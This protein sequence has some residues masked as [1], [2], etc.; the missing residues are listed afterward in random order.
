VSYSLSIRWR[1]RLAVALV[2][3][4]APYTL[5][6]TV[7]QAAPSAQARLATVAKEAP[8]R[9]V[10]AIAQF[11]PSFSER[12]AKA[13]VRRHGGKVTARVPLINGLAVRLPA[14]QAAILARNGNV[15]ALTLNSRVHGT[16]IEDGALATRFP[17]TIKAD[18]V[19]RRGFTGKGIGVAV[20]DTGIAGDT[21]DF[22]DATG[23]S[24][25]IANAVTSRTATTAGDGFGHGT[26]VAGI[27]AG[28]SLNRD[29]R[30]PFYGKYIGVAPDANLIAVKASDEAG[31]STVLDVI[32]GLQFVVDHKA[33]FNIRV[34]NLSVSTDTPQSYKNDPLDAA[35]EYAWQKG[36]VVVA[37]SGNR[38]A[39]ADA[40]RYAPANDPFVISVGGSDENGDYGRGE[41]ASW[42]STGRT[43]DGFAKPEVMAPGA[44]IV[45]VLSQSS[46]FLALC[47]NCSIGGS[48]FKAGG[49]SMAAPVVAGAVALLLQARPNLTPDQVKTILTQTDKPIKGQAG[50][51]VIDIEQALYTP[52][53]TVSVNKGLVPNLLIAAINRA[54]ID[55]SRWTRSSWSSAT[56]AFAAG[57]ARSS[58]S[59][60]G[61]DASASAIDPT[62]SSWS[63]SSWSSAG[64]DASEESAAYEQAIDDQQAA[65]ETTLA[66]PIPV[67]AVL[68][69]DE[70]TAEEPAPQGPVA[71]PVTPAP[72]VTP[73]APVTEA[74]R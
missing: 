32:N 13:L 1:S 19:W 43:Q 9:K 6:E 44:H 74:V 52:T 8:A 55:I 60:H 57:W 58:W 45:S 3:V 4:A 16:A 51:G 59:C 73:A 11:K 2:A 29:R 40:V 41:R 50:A 15:L 63:R 35:V 30:D 34:V 61:C 27:I 22:K 64:E 37:A 38:G 39:N 62:R 42:S 47:P 14:K 53:S 12:R 70:P 68:P 18:K 23:A 17:K 5:A 28:N 69:T 7:A 20:I 49:T 71:K 26:H 72:T 24:R 33:E 67:D 21:V 54:G 48:Y 66:P 36:I 25:V 46:A 10:T 56:G 31:N 65:D